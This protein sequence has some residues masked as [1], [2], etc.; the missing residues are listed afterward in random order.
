MQRPT[1]AMTLLLACLS[2][3]SLAFGQ[4]T[5]PTGPP[6]QETCDPMEQ[7]SF[8]EVFTSAQC[9]TDFL[10]AVA[11]LSTSNANAWM[12]QH[13]SCFH[14]WAHFT[15]LAF[16]RHDAK[17]AA[18]AWAH[19]LSL[20]TERLAT[21]PNC[22]DDACT[23]QA[24][25]DL[26]TRGQTR[27]ISEE[28]KA[29][30]A[31]FLQS[32]TT[33]TKYDASM[34]KAFAAV[35]PIC[36]Y[37]LDVPC[38]GAMNKI[39]T[40]MYPRSYVW[41]GEGFTF[42]M[43]PIVKE[44]FGDDLMQKYATR[45]A[46]DLLHSAPEI[47]G[48]P[49]DPSA[50]YT[51]GM[52][53]FEGDSDRF[54][55]F[56]MVYATRGAAWATAFNLAHEDT[57]PLFAAF[58]IVSAAMGVL[59]TSAADSGSAW[60]YGPNTTA[61]CFQPKPYHFWMAAGYAY[62]LKKDGYSDITSRRVA[63]LLG[64]MY[65]LGST[66]MERDPDAV[67]FVEPYETIVNRTRREVTH[68]ALGAAFG[69]APGQSSEQNFDESLAKVMNSAIPLLTMSADEMRAKIRDLP[70]KWRYWSELTGFYYDR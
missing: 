55:K 12:T 30:T 44:I 24:V 7:D 69:L 51:L 23:A 25:D 43:I 11:T 52:R 68:H 65:E 15:W 18:V 8:R 56:M 17:M 38:I 41:S 70:T 5:A 58:M 45:L 20:I 40:L 6:W 33:S 1:F 16:S 2:A 63:R 31:E 59:D 26:L 62:L 39:L 49:K 53:D 19:Q 14:E 42:S 36:L 4:Q 10:D 9:E 67:F 22:Q 37:H 13:R 29:H 50:I 35:T 46:L 66:T 60:S 3:S 64:A 32:V 54:W 28:A 48:L 21:A 47:G 34:Q 61:T 27:A 57:K